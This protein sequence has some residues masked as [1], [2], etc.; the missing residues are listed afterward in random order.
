MRSFRVLALLVFALGAAYL[1]ASVLEVGPIYINGSGGMGPTGYDPPGYDLQIN[2]SGSNAS[3]DSVSMIGVFVDYPASNFGATVF[4]PI[5]PCDF[6]GTGTCSTTIDGISGFGALINLGGGDGLIQVF[7]SI[8]D[9]AEYNLGPLVAEAQVVTYGYITS[10]NISPSNQST[11]T[12]SFVSPEPST[13]AL[14]LIAC[15]ALHIL[16]PR[17]SSPQKR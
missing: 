16:R 14:C 1:S 12:F 15:A 3:G 11:E 5:G 17:R 10:L 2:V 9:P 7:S 8:P 13:G 4:N 6:L